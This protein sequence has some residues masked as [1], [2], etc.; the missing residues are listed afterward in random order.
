MAN[1]SEN[2][3]APQKALIIKP[4][5]LGDVITALPVLR[6]LKR[7]HPATKVDWLISTACMDILRDDGQINALVPFERKRLGRCWRSADAAGALWQFYRTLAGGEYDW[8]IDLQGLVRSGIFSLFTHAKLRAGF[9]DA[10]EGGHI[11]YNHAFTPQLPHTV[12]R[13][14]E[15]ARSLNLDAKPQ[16]MYLKI[17]DEAKKTIQNMLPGGDYIVCVPPTRWNTKKYPVRH[18]RKVIAAISARITVVISGSPAADEM[19]LC[20]SVAENM[21]PQVINMAGKTSL[22]EMAALIAGSR[23]VIC[24]DSAA[25]FIAPAVG[26]DCVTLLGPT[27]TEMTGPYLKGKALVAD[28]PCSGCLKKRCNHITCMQSIQPELVISAAMDMIDRH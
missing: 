19:T 7:T 12:D 25:K 21:G 24:S 3:S 17:D 5:S 14:I 11:F 6:G 10:R 28:V 9:G 13:N 2:I 15:L 16:D 23:G 27:R 20:Q 1:Q 4:S 18:W 26:V 8:V 22:R